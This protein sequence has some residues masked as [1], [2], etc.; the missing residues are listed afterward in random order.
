MRT[1][2]VALALCPPFVLA[3]PAT[4]PSTQLSS[5]PGE[6]KLTFAPDPTFATEFKAPAGT[7]IRVYDDPS[8]RIELDNTTIHVSGAKPASRPATQ[9]SFTIFDF[10]PPT[11]VN[12]PAKIMN[13]RPTP[14]TKPSTRPITIEGRDGDRAVEPHNAR[15]IEGR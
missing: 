11:K 1:M 13:D 7:M 8:K 2:I 6:F 10:G 5:T 3:Q 15:P 4:R 12:A 9:D 14:A